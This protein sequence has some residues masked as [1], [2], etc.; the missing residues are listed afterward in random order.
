MIFLRLSCC[1][2]VF[3][4]VVDC[5]IY[6]VPKEDDDTESLVLESVVE[7]SYTLLPV[8]PPLLLVGNSD[9]KGL[10]FCCRNCLKRVKPMN[11]PNETVIPRAP[12]AVIGIPKKID[13]TMIAKIRRMQFNAA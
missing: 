6:T 12:T 9:D 10:G 7:L 2:D 13:V 5:M 3:V 1:H 11:P 4:M 8:T